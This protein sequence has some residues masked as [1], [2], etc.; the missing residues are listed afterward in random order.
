MSSIQENKYYPFYGGVFSQ[1]YPSPF[2][3]RGIEFNCAEQFMMAGKALY[4][5]DEQSYY[6]IMG[7]DNPAKQKQLGRKV[8]GFDYDKWMQVA[9]DIVTMGNVLKFKQ[10]KDL[11]SILEQV[12]SDGCKLVE[13]SP[14]D[15]IWGIGLSEGNPDCHNKSKWQGRNLLGKAIDR[16]WDVLVNDDHAEHDALDSVVYRIFNNGK[17]FL[18]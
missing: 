8:K 16:A 6:K 14:V 9:F 1:W 11:Y 2:M 17:L 3:Y 18:G 15:K 10:N 12:K 7:T 13:A 4:F 5:V